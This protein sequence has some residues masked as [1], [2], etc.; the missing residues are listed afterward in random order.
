MQEK[1]SDRP[2]LKPPRLSS[3]VTDSGQRAT[4]PGFLEGE[5]EVGEARKRGRRRKPASPAPPRTAPVGRRDYS[6]HN[7]YFLSF[8]FF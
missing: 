6:Y 1:D 2:S 7:D 5:G 4:R 3:S 8:S